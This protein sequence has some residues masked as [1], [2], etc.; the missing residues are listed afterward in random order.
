M[1]EGEFVIKSFSETFEIDIG[2]IDVTVDLRAGFGCDI[3]GGDHHAAKATLTRY[4]GDIDHIFAPYDRVVVSES[5]AGNVMSE[6]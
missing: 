2:G 6:G 4:A 3:S 5:D 1:R